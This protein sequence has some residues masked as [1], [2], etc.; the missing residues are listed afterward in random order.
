MV[1]LCCYS[2][3]SVVRGESSSTFIAYVQNIIYN[4]NNNKF[5]NQFSIRYIVNPE[6]HV[7]KAFIEQVDNFLRE[8]FHQTTMT[9]ISNVL[10]NKYVHYCIN[11]VLRENNKKSKKSV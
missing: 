11:N 7:N 1:I 10:K 9:G 5:I 2:V 4:N 8:T 3:V 6:L